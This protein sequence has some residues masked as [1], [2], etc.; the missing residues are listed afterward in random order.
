MHPTHGEPQQAVGRGTAREA[1]W[2][3]LVT[4]VAIF[5]ICL[6]SWLPQVGPEE[7]VPAAVFPW[8]RVTSEGWEHGDFSP[9]AHQ[10]IPFL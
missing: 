2:H 4:W 1:I 8:S 3:G 7:M 5:D 6:K 9:L 10:S